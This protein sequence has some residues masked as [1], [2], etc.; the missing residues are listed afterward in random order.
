MKVMVIVTVLIIRV[1]IA[2]FMAIVGVGIV[3][4]YYS[5]V[6]NI[7]L[8]RWLLLLSPVIVHSCYCIVIFIV[9]VT[10]VSDIFIVIVVVT[11]LVFVIVL[12]CWC[13]CLICHFVC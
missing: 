13:A 11:C 10:I 12:V 7:L 2:A 1:V 6:F 3:G 4:G 9:M 8:I 5:L